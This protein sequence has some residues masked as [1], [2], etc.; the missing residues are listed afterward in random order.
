MVVNLFVVEL[1]GG[2]TDLIDI[3]VV[4]VVSLEDVATSDWVFYLLLSV[5]SVLVDRL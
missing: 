5:L 3:V 2:S 4:V 1:D